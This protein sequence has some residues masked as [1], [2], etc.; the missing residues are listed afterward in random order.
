MQHADQ[1]EE[2]AR[3]AEIDGNLV[4]EAPAQQFRSL[5]VQAAS[6]HIDRLDL[7]RAGPLDGGEIA[8][9]DE[10]VVLDDAAE[11][12]KRQ[13]DPLPRNIVGAADVEN[14]AVVLD[15]EVEMKWPIITGDWRE[16]V[17]LEQVEDSNCPLVLD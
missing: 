14:E 6:P 2:P 3:R 10:E 15:G 17:F 11:R 7:R 8:L 9:A 5:V 4:G 12:G 16:A 13:G 1:R